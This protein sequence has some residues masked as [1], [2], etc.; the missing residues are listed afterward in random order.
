M[1]LISIKDGASVVG[2]MGAGCLLISLVDAVRGLT[3]E[4][5]SEIVVAILKR[6]PIYASV[7]RESGGKS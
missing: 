7:A 2:V 6:R 3:Y 4:L 5:V 1:M